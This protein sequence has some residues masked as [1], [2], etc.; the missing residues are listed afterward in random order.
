MLRIQ[1]RDLNGPVPDPEE[2]LGM[3]KKALLKLAEEYTKAESHP[4]FKEEMEKLIKAENYDELNDRFYTQLDFGTGG[5]RGVIGGGYNRMNPLMVRRATQGLAY[6]ILEN[7]GVQN[8]SAAIAYDSRNFSRDFAEVAALTFCA[9]G[10]KTYLFS[11]LR[12]T[13]ELSFAVRKLGCTSG[14]V[15]TA[16]HNPKEYNGYKVYWSDGGQIISPHDKGIIEE[17]RSVDGEIP[18]ISRKEAE[19]QGLLVWIDNE[20][21]DEFVELIKSYSLRPDLVRQ[22]GKDLKV[23]YTPL[24]GTGTMMVERILSEAGIE[25]VTVPEQREPDGSFPTVEFPNP[26]EAS[27]MKMS[28]DLATKVKADL[29]MGTDPDADRLGIAVPD[30]D[31][32]YVLIT[33]NQLGA[34]LEDYI[35]LSKKELGTMPAAPRIIKTIV[36][37][38]LQRVLLRK[39]TAQ[40]FMTYLP[41][42]SILQIL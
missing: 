24:H 34:L 12:P 26:E 1:C 30:K 40:K 25:V 20:I 19:E 18:L 21:D 11:A 28:L 2:Q 29:V 37:T 27:A 3:D 33:G 15:I 31:G 13:P 36:T 7:S 23:V 9:N 16:S 14:I 8:P 42:S 41:D 39:A 6:Y 5:L 32:K 22:R 17:V 38:E 35:L 10:I 4:Y